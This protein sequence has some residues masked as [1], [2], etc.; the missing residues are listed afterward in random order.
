MIRVPCFTPLTLSFASSSQIFFQSYN[1]SKNW[2]LLPTHG[3]CVLGPLIP[4]FYRRKI[5][6]WVNWYRSYIHVTSKVWN[7]QTCIGPCSLFVRSYD[8]RKRLDFSI[9]GTQ[10]SRRKGGRNRNPILY[11]KRRRETCGISEHS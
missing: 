3:V 1:N 10:S 8:N 6:D 7:V 4:L 9:D 2:L 5:V 11:K